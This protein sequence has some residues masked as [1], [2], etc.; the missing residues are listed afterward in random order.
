MGLLKKLIR[1]AS[2]K[3]LSYLE[4]NENY[5]FL[6]NSY[7]FENIS[8]EAS[9]FILKRL[10][11]RHYNKDE[12]IFKQDNPGIS[13][14]LI[15]KGSVE[16][17]FRT[18]ND[19]KIIYS[20]LEAGALFGEISIVSTS[21]RTASAKST[22]NDTVLLTLSSFDIDD[23]NKNFPGDGLQILKGITNTVIK[24]LITVTKNFRSAITTIDE[25]KGKLEKY[26]NA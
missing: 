3:A 2:L 10:E 22:S 5:Q 8:T 4:N 1:R 21:Y 18:E 24:T 7:L 14:F 23:I 12:F 17:Y 25:L 13:L 16:I 19:E 6:K 15:K 26:E 9:L 11:E 20:N